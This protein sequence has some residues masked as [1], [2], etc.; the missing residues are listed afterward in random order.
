MINTN[1][2]NLDYIGEELFNKIR[3]RFPSVTIGN[4]EGIVTNVPGEARFFD[5][6]FKEGNSE[7]G[8]V[9]ISLDDKSLNVMYSNNFLE[10][11][12]SITKEKWYGFLRELRFFAKKRLLTFDTRDITKSNLNRRDYKF[13]ATNSGD[14]TMSESKMYG[15]SKTSYQ[16]LGTARLGRAS[17]RL[18]TLAIAVGCRSVRAMPGWAARERMGLPCSRRRASSS[19]ANIT[20]A[21]LL[22]P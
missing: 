9:S 18:P 1:M 8:K 12:D 5:F 3:G 4:Q 15:T 22:W 2:K 7:A 6:D 20:L 17:K 19:R 10:G 16:D 13:L 14:T 11:Q 21:S